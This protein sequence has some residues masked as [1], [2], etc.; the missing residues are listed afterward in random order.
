MEI[1]SLTILGCSLLFLI[2]LFILISKYLNYK[3]EKML[4]KKEKMFIE[5]RNF[6]LNLDIR[7]QVDEELDGYIL[8]AFNE[9]ISLDP[10][11]I[12]IKIITKEDE[13]KIM[14]NVSE[15]A[16]ALMS[17]TFVERLGCVYDVN[18]TLDKDTTLL[19]DLVIKKVYLLTLNYAIEKNKI[20]E[21]N[22]T[23]IDL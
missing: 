16:L 15:R 2:T 8:F 17:N 22:S 10:H 3:K 6:K 5:D 4:Y 9:Y 11:F 1:L 13:K 19:T 12:G 18:L 23:E 20:K 14:K 7:R 21:D